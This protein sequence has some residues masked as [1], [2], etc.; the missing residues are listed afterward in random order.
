MTRGLRLLTLAALVA[1]CSGAKREA[2]SL[3]AAVDR[4]RQ[5]DPAGKVERA[6]DLAA[7]PCTDAEVCAAKA[8]CFASAEPTALGYSLKAEVESSLDDLKAGRITKDQAEARDLPQKLDE[9]SRQLDRGQAALG[10]CDTKITALR[11]KYA[12]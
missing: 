7:V 8:A 3:V 4:Y 11:V 9:A 12:L 5:A 10:A 2:A 1:A 6:K